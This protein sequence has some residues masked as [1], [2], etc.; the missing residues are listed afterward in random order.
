MRS[1]RTWI[2]VLAAGAMVGAYATTEDYVDGAAFVIQAAGMQG[3]AR[4]AAEW[5]TEAVSEQPVRVP[6]RGGELDGRWYRPESSRERAVLLVPG[7]HA[8]GIK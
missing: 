4:T 8:A 1:R 7:V 6:W 2:A 3:F 5:T